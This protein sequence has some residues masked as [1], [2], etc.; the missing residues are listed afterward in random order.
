ME[1]TSQHLVVCTESGDSAL[2]ILIN[3]VANLA[4]FS[5]ALKNHRCT[6]ISEYLSD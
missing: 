6:Q 3:F 4:D 2:E 1:N 5:L